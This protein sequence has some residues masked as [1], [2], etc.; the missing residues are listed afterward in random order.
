MSGGYLVKSIKISA[1]IIGIISTSLGSTWI[2]TQIKDRNDI[3]KEIADKKIF[4]EN[5]TEYH[6]PY[7]KKLENISTDVGAIK[8]QNNVILTL[9]L[10]RMTWEEKQRA[11]KSL[12]D[13][14][15]SLTYDMA[16]KIVDGR[17]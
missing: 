8:A 10:G 1:M 7:T 2:Y 11:V 13:R 16:Y 5:F 4:K 9:Q 3:K 6:E 15:S 17:L 14:D 12:M